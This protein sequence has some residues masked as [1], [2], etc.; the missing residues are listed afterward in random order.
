MPVRRIL[1]RT[2]PDAA[3]D[4]RT[5]PRLVRG[6]PGMAVLTGG[7]TGVDTLAARAA[8]RAGLPVHLIFPA[9]YRQEDGSLT[10]SRRRVLS[11]AS[12]HALASG[13][14]RYRTWTSV[15]LCDAV[16]LLDPAGGDGCLETAT[17]AKR[18]DRPLLI[19][20]PG[21]ITSA[22]VAAWLD[23]TDARVLMVAGCRASLLARRRASQGL[24]AQLTE[25]AAGAS[26]R[27][28]RLLAAA[29]TGAGRVR[30]AGCRGLWLRDDP[31]IAGDD[32]G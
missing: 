3:S 15:Y 25:I 18:L 30:A 22:E 29:L 5:L 9:G 19:P 2:A 20:C 21:R 23:E 1:V 11:G 17:A 7:Q 13:S 6:S 27:H 32:V 31:Q 14:F 12:L 28:V 10:A 16:V 24:R 26:E 8:L 4:E